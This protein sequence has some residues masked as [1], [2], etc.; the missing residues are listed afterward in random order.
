[1]SDENEVGTRFRISKSK[2]CKCLFGFFPGCS[3]LRS[4]CFEVNIISDSFYTEGQCS[5]THCIGIEGVLHIIH[6]LD[7][8]RMTDGITDSHSRHGT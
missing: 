6:G 2:V 3:D 5:L 4:A 1:M 7:Q 8:L